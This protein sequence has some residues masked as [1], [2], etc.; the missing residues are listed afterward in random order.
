MREAFAALSAQLKDRLQS[1]L[2]Q[3]MVPGGIEM[4][5]GGLNDAAF[6]PMVMCGMG[7]VFVDV[8]DDT[9]FA[10]CPVAEV[11]AAALIE[12]IKGRARLRG[13]RGTPPADEAALRAL[14]VRVAQLLHACPE[15]RELDLN[16]VMVRIRLDFE[17]PLVPGR[18]IRH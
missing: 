18:R 12:R 5:I 13:A 10:M 2:V 6:G 8:L 1:V 15:I 7:G 16:P 17:R 3:P 14:L 4:V 9:A 11:D